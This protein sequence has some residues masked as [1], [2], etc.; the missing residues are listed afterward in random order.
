MKSV[1]ALPQTRPGSI[2]LI[3]FFIFILFAGG[4]PVAMRISYSEMP[5]FLV[6]VVRFGVG[7]LIFWILAAFNRLR[8]PKGKALVGP[9]LYGVLSIGISFALLGWG[10]VKTP[11]SLAAIFLALVPMM[12]VILSSLEGVESLTARGIFGSLLAVIGT[13]IAVGAASSSHE[14]SIIHILALIL[15]TIFLAQGSIVVK[16]YPINPPIITNALGMAVG[17]II[18][19]VVSLIGG[20]SWVIPSQLSTWAALGYLVFF[21]SILAFLMYLQVINKWTAS[22]ASYGFVIMPFVTVIISAF[23]T[24]EKITVYFLLGIMVVI[25]GVVIGALLPPKIKISEECITC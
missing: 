25:S 4:G 13:M 11:A 6:G 9:L 21:V 7:S 12:T 24:N 22:G 2:V 19:A 8:I 20:E 1:S 14:I 10:L 15:G 17:A 18:L 23:L 16:R 5:P 3:Y